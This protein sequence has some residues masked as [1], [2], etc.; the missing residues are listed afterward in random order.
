M[1][2][3]IK[4]RMKQRYITSRFSLREVGYCHREL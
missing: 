4:V 2:E 3:G 1:K